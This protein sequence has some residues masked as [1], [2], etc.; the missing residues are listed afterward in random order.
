MLD[1]RKLLISGTACS[2]A[3]ALPA[4]P[5]LAA[6][7]LYDYSGVPIKEIE[8]IK[9]VFDTLE[10][11]RFGLLGKARAFGFEGHACASLDALRDSV[12]DCALVYRVPD[13]PGRIEHWTVIRQKLDDWFGADNIGEHMR[14]LAAKPSI[15]RHSCRDMLETGNYA[16]LG[17][18][19]AYVRD[20]LS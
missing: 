10:S 3:L 7:P 5:V 15:W 4:L 2:F 16:D 18:V 13:I 12:H 20:V 17:S 8:K 11:Y 9:R 14:W 19:S 1:R 6:T